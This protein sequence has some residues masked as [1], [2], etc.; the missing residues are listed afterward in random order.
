M[1]LLTSTIYLLF[2]LLIFNQYLQRLLDSKAKVMWAIIFL[3]TFPT[4][5]FFNSV[6]TESMFFCFVISTFYFLH[7]KNYL[8]AGIFAYAAALTRIVGIFL[9][10]PFLVLFAVKVYEAYRNKTIWTVIKENFSLLFAS[11]FPVLGFGTYS[12]YLWK[13]SGDPLLFFHSQT[14]FSAG[15]QTS[16][17]L[18][19][20]VIYR[21]LKIFF[22]ADFNFTYFVAVIE[23]SFF[24]FALGILSWQFFKLIKNREKLNT[25]LLGINLF[26]FASLLLPTLTGTFLS[27]PRFLIVMPAIFIAL[28]ELKGFKI[29]VGITTVFVVLHIILLGYFV[30][31]YFIS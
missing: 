27:I 24:I 5:F 28:A 23:F 22:T 20:Q 8:V 10:I 4:S 26:S 18:F 2:G 15:R 31:G 13:V 29:K 9:I 1:G 30:Q 3:L 25:H 19:P 14:A 17:I 12:F 6:Y 21:Y 7:K 11:L 16:L